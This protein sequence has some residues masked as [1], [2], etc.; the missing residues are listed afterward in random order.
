MRAIEGC[1]LYVLVA[2]D[3]CVVRTS[4]KGLMACLPARRK[5]KARREGRSLAVAGSKLWTAG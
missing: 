1:S 5:R 3:L 2:G 4:V